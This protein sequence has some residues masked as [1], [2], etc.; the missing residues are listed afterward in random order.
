MMI[1]QVHLFSDRMS[2]RNACIAAAMTPVRGSPTQQRYQ[3]IQHVAHAHNLMQQNMHSTTLQGTTHIGLQS[4][5]RTMLAAIL[6]LAGVLEELVGVFEPTCAMSDA[7]CQITVIALLE[8][9]THKQGA[10]GGC[11]HS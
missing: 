7:V 9:V 2:M 1:R 5:V 3:S 11:E 6:I 8:L 10:L 4:A